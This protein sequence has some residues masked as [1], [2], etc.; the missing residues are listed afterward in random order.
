MHFGK[1]S[2]ME[3]IVF[4]KF[5]IIMPPGFVHHL[6]S[7]KLMTSRGGQVNGAMLLAQNYL[8]N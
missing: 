3:K 1:K 2:N 8:E 6:V 4:S 5:G 7:F